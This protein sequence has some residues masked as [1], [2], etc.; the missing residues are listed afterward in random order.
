MKKVILLV[1]AATLALSLSPMFAQNCNSV[2]NDETGTLTSS[3]TSAINSA[4][5]RLLD[6]GIMPHVIFAKGNAPTAA[7]EARYESA[8]PN[9]TAKGQRAA[10][11]LSFVVE[12]S[13]RL[14][15]VYFGGALTPAFGGVD[16][17][18]NRFSQ[19]ANPYFRQGHFGDGLA[20]AM[21]DFGAANAAFH[22]QA[23]HPVQ[24]ETVINNNEKATDLAPVASVFKWVFGLL[25]IAALIGLVV[26]LIR[27]RNAAKEAAEASQ[28]GAQAAMLKATTAFRNADST[29]PGY[30][31]VSSQYS[32]LSGQVSYDPNTAG[33]SAAAYDEMAEAWNDLTR[34]IR[35]LR[36]TPTYSS[37]PAPESAP[38]AAAA[39][40]GAHKHHRHDSY[41]D[42]AP[43]PVAAPAPYTPPP[44]VVHETTVVDRSG[45]ND[46]LTGVLIGNALSDREDRREAREEREDRYAREDR[47]ERPSYSDPEPSRSSSG[48]DSSWGSSSGS[49]DDSSS[50]SGSDSS[51]SDSSSS[52][53]SSSFDSGSS[54]S[55][56]SW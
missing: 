12:P 2:I 19:A 4:A 29:L 16:A 37:D 30:V 46:L 9:W 34:T 44:T 17:V 49:S 41:Y 32:E 28:Q 39:A 43:Q 55:D 36:P 22:D 25:F 14:K 8:C 6:Q 21:K 26:F 5:S 23:Q 31:E 15:N 53:D 54:G 45:S 51:W 10:N 50:S 18:N 35:A 7:T 3:D 42:S 11:L 48:S 52:S 13:A 33:L 38:K 56:S 24:H 1:T 20:A 40:A 27:R 47:Y